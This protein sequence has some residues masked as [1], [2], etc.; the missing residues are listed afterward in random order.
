MLKLLLKLQR[1]TEL[2]FIVD[3]TFATPSLWKPLESGADIVIHSATK[4]F[5]GH[6]NLT[7]GV[8]CGNDPQIMKSA[9]EYRKLIGHMLS[10]DDAYRLHTQIQTFGLRFRQQCLNASKGC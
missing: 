10:A 5:S 7:A 6:G 9:I 3:N 1:S 4:Y 8:L 2:K